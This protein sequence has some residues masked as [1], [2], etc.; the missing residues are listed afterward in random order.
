MVILWLKFLIR[1]LIIK[2][3]INSK[4]N[5]SLLSKEEKEEL[6]NLIKTKG[7]NDYPVRE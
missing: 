1:F 4:N 7:S 6:K 5:L 3:R 2:N